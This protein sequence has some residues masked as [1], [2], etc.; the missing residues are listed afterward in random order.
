VVGIEMVS[1]NEAEFEPAA[2]MR[3]AVSTANGSLYYHAPQTAPE[4]P[5]IPVTMP[6]PWA[7]RP[8]A[9]TFHTPLFS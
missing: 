3:K 4:A 2:S 7:V 5:T 1:R 8:P 6:G 9:N